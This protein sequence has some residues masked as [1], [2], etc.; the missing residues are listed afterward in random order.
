VNTFT[1]TVLYGLIYR[2]NYITY[3]YRT[4]LKSDMSLN[5]ISIAPCS[6]MGYRTYRSTHILKLS[7]RR[8]WVDSFRPS[9]IYPT[10]TVTENH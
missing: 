3:K 4:K 7:T 9:R 6:R 2:C 5:L 10:E 8:I 1:E